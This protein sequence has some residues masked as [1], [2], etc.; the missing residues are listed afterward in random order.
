VEVADEGDENAATETLKLHFATL[1]EACW[2]VPLH[3][4]ALTAH[5]YEYDGRLISKVRAS[6]ASTSLGR[7]IK[8][9]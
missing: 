8:H 7:V 1:G 2:Q 3:L 6:R 9:H 4:V 5:G